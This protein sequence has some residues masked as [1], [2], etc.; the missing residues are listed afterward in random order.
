MVHYL[1]KLHEYRE[2]IKP[3][4]VTLEQIKQAL[5]AFFGVKV[6][7]EKKI[8]EQIEVC[9]FPKV[10]TSKG[11]M[12]AWEKAGRPNPHKFFARYKG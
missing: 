10:K 9:G 8:D 5:F 6:G 1:D 11:A 2:A 7:N 4:E 12:D 3:A